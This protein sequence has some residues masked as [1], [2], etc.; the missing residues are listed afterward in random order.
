MIT[1]E[2][3]SHIDRIWFKPVVSPVLYHELFEAT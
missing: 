2:I 3:R 1:G